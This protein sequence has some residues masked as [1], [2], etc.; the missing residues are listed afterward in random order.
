VRALAVALLLAAAA[1]FVAASAGDEL[2]RSVETDQGAAAAAAEQKGG[3]VIRLEWKL[4]GFLGFLAGLF[5]PSHGDALLTF[6]PESE[7]NVDIELLI[8]A[9]K[10][11]GEYFLY[12]A[13]I[14]ENSSSTTAVWSSYRFR[15]SNKEREQ[16]IDE[17]DVIDY[18]SMIYHM[19]WHPPQTTV[20]M[21]IWSGGKTYPVEIEP[22][23]PGVRKV[24]GRKIDVRGYEVRGVT[25]RG[26]PSFDER[27]WVY[28]A[29]DE[30]ATPVEIVG[31]R[32]LARVRIQLTETSGLPSR[33]K[34][35]VA[36]DRR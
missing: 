2:T 31:K 4:T 7:S 34:G 23:D 25:V 26:Q 20:R 10:R 9:P 5:V 35:G 1:S 14:D 8:T 19:R 15:D 3:E 21:K 33:P 11:D 32:S 29:R 28:F 17:P 13:Q 6:V 30:A 36:A 27:F 24:A 22:L 16:Q 12:G 18:A